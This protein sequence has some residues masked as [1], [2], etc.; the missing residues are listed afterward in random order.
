MAIIK[1]SRT[2]AGVN[3]LPD[4]ATR[5]RHPL[6]QQS[7]TK[8][9][10]TISPF[11]H[12]NSRPSEHQRRSSSATAICPRWSEEKPCSGNFWGKVRLNWWIIRKIRLWYRWLA[13]VSAPLGYDRADSAVPKRRKYLQHSHYVRK[14]RLVRLC[15][16]VL[17]AFILLS[18]QFS[19]RWS[20][21]SRFERAKPSTLET[22]W[23]GA[24]LVSGSARIEFFSW[25]HLHSF[26]EELVIRNSSPKQF[27]Q[28]LD[29]IQRLRILRT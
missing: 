20:M 28:A 27:L 6:S 7:I 1:A 21:I 16:T 19:F 18:V 3:P 11:R 5:E 26:F 4:F 2:I 9:A 24:L 15:E 10:V 29:F 8:V 13:Q 17:L 25:H 14:N 22:P 12:L 23:L